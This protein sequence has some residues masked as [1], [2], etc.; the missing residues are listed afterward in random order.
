TQ[1]VENVSE[2]ISATPKK[3]PH[4]AVGT[5]VVGVPAIAAAAAIVALGP[6]GSSSSG[7]A[8]T[9]EV[10]AASCGKGW[11][12]QKTGEHTFQMKNTGDVPA[13]VYL[14]DPATSAVYGEI[15][16]LAPGTT[17]PL[18]ATL[19]AGA[20]A[21]RCVPNGKGTMTSAVQHVTGTGISKTAV[22]PI[23]EKDLDAPLEEYRNYVT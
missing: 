1:K 15:E 4:W 23:S 5:A 6:S 14:L 11:T 19:G 22:V 13:E 3:T 21:W 17:R 12:D 9:I 7:D 20:Y 8:Q 10:S 16:G 2:G 18:T